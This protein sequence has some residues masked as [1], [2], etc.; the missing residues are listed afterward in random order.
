MAKWKI[1]LEY[2][3]EDGCKS[4]VCH[5]DTWEGDTDNP[6]ELT[7]ISLDLAAVLCAFEHVGKTVP[8]DGDD[9]RDAFVEQ[10]DQNW[11]YWPSVENLS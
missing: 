9:V 4:S 3:S 8:C 1:T 11:S 7:C 10:F 5:E 2:E 6:P